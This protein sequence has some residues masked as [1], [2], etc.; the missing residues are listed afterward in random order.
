MVGRNFF[1]IAN[2]G[3]AE[4]W[5]FESELK[6]Q[7]DRVT[8]S[9]WYTYNDF[10]FDI[11]AQNAR[12]FEPARHKIGSTVR[13]QANDWLTLNANYRFTSVT[14]DKFTTD[15]PEHHR[16]DLTATFAIES[17]NAELQLGVTDIFDET[18]VLI[19]DQSARSVA[20]ETPGRSLF[21]QF[22]MSF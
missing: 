18:D 22:H 12:A 11:T 1:Q 7:S 15:V 5:G 4:A 9:V 20:T 8:A 10:S 2:I 14:V 21:A 16:L 19:F 13:V 17:M 3:G 6:H